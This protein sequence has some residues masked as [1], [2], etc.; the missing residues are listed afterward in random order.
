MEPKFLIQR[1]KFIGLE[2]GNSFK[3]LLRSHLGTH[4]LTPRECKKRHGFKVTQPLT[5]NS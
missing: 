5:A 3:Q 1:N 2:C 4:G